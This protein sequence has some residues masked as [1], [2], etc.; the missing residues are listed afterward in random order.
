MAMLLAVCAFNLLELDLTIS[1]C[2]SQEYMTREA[3]RNGELAV[4]DSVTMDSFMKVAHLARSSA[5][6]V[7]TSHYHG[8]KLLAR[9]KKSAYQQCHIS[10]AY[11]RHFC[12]TASFFSYARHVLHIQNI[13]DAMLGMMVGSSLKAYVLPETSVLAAMLS[14]FVSNKLCLSVTE[15]KVTG[16]PTSITTNCMFL[17]E[18]EGLLKALRFTGIRFYHPISC[19]RLTTFS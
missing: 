2:L 1:L 5:H 6:T 8:T 18:L 14:H 15:T 10:G 9:W 7:F 11:C 19:F 13:F 3:K 4:F 17:Q 16:T 12:P